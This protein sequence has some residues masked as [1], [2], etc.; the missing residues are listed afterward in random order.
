[1]GSEF[2]SKMATRR[3]AARAKEPRYVDKVCVG[4]FVMQ[5]SVCQ[6]NCAAYPLIDDGAGVACARRH[7]MLYV[8]YR[9]TCGRA[10]EDLCQFLARDIR[11]AQRLGAKALADDLAVV[12]RL[13]AEN[14]PEATIPLSP[15]A[16][17]RPATGQAA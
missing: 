8:T 7:E 13:V 2:F 4:G 11:D 16:T 1:M 10:R 6:V 3:I 5:E 14:C 9:N 17:D 15:I 12:L